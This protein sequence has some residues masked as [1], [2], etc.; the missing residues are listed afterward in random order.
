MKHVM[1]LASKNVRNIRVSRTFNKRFL[2]PLI[3]IAFLP[4]NAV[5]AALEGSLESADCTSIK[6]WAWDNTSPTMRIKVN[7]YDVK[8]PQPILLATITAQSYRVDLKDAGKGDGKYGF[9]ALLPASIRNAL[10]HKISVQFDGTTTELNNSPLTTATNCYGKLNDTGYQKCA[11]AIAND[12]TC[13][14]TG[15]TGQDGD[16]GRDVLAAT[17]K[18]RK[19]GKGAGGFD[20]TKIAN[21]GSK[22]PDTAVMGAGKKKWA[23][24]LDNVTGLMWQLNTNGSTWFEAFNYAKAANTANLCGKNDWRLPKKSELVSI[25]DFGQQK[26]AI[27]TSYFPNTENYNYW[28]SDTYATFN[29][30]AWYV[31][32]TTG[33]SGAVDKVVGGVTRLVR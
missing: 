3:S 26:P 23:C 4:Y 21:D 5:Y 14:A 13:P 16:V 2:V 6:G 30:A 1:G 33:K 8:L 7:I 9:S 15:F 27:D 19:T 17:K 22:L 25:V 18:L 20:F 11:D 24:T 10:H 32:F 12:L 29:P 31:D 28:A